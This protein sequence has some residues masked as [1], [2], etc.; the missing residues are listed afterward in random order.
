M[1][2]LEL[3]TYFEKQA[4]APLDFYMYAKIAADFP[5]QQSQDLIQALDILSQPRFSILKKIF[6]LFLSDESIYEFSTQ[7][8]LQI[9]DDGY[10]YHPE[11]NKE[12]HDLNEICFAYEI[13]KSLSHGGQE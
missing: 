2:C 10:F 11:T 5:K 13:G 1:L 9:L 6:F 8:I 3:L 12:I 4:Q 7:D